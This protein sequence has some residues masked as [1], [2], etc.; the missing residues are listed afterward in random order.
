[1]K[2]NHHN[3]SYSSHTSG[4][5]GASSRRT[6]AD[7]RHGPIGEDEESKW[8]HRDKLAQIESQELQAAG[9]ILPKPRS[10]SRVSR[11][12]NRHHSD[13]S[14]LHQKADGPTSESNGPARSRTNSV[15]ADQPDADADPETPSWDLRLPDEIAEEGDL[16]FCVA[17]G[18]SKGGTRIPVAKLSPAPIPMDYLERPTPVSRKNTSD[19]ASADVDAITY[20]K[21]RSRSASSKQADASTPAAPTAK[22]SAT[23]ISPKK[24][25]GA[26]KPS[27]R[28]VSAGQRP[29]TRS[30]PKDTSRPSTRSGE[31]AA[32]STKQPE[33]DPPWLLSSY[34]PDPRLPP[35]QQLLPTVARRLQQ[36][37]W[38]KEGK[39]GNVLDKEFRP[40]NDEGFAQPPDKAE[41][42]E[43]KPEE[44]PDA[45]EWPL[46]E[47]SRGTPRP[48]S[49]YST[50]PKVQEG[51][52]NPP[53]V[54][55]GPDQ[56]R[57]AEA[58]VRVPEEKEGK[59]GCACCVVM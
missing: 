24:P 29:K 6:T 30:G 42:P 7:S 15:A 59:A 58:V 37:K 48:P 51:P 22:R 45:R 33:G 47:E 18:L 27:S 53:P 43:E 3:D 50:M 8:I 46:S 36:E 21:P 57:P 40:L 13:Q 52:A 49:V 28:A 9:F 4:R 35:D 23:D 19:G 25:T 11:R 38:E 31:L 44:K 14:S 17:S 54:P 55:M 56:A 39:F 10:H 16:G 34:R 26:R 12:D 2:G 5:N 41:Q 32:G 1:M 20:P